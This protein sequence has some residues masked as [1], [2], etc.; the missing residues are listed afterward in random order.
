[1]KGDF[2][3]SA[4]PILAQVFEYDKSA[5]AWGRYD[6]DGNLL[7]YHDTLAQAVR[8]ALPPELAEWAAGQPDQKRGLA[9]AQL[10]A[11]GAVRPDPEAAGVYA[12][13]Y[14][15]DGYT[16]DYT[17]NVPAGTCTCPD[18]NIRQKACKH[19]LAATWLFAE[20]KRKLDALCAEAIRTELCEDGV[21]RLKYAPAPATLSLWDLARQTIAEH[22]HTDPWTPITIWASADGTR[23]AEITHAQTDTTASR[24]EG[25]ADA[26]YLSLSGHALQLRLAIIHYDI[27]GLNGDDWRWI[28]TAAQYKAWVADIRNS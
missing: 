10:I 20:Y 23:T 25:F 27:L 8:A 6:G 4:T 24:G 14:C 11:Q 18:F 22:A 26:L 21:L 13:S 7:H 28:C 9:A 2:T 16:G 5:K 12:Q 19:L 3:M 1:M 15:R 17:I